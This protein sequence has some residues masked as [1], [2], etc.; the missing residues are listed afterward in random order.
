[1]KVMPEQLI[2]ALYLLHKDL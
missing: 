2:L 1:M